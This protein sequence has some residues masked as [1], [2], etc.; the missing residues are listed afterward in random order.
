LDRALLGT[1][2]G[3]LSGRRR[4]QAR[5]IADLLPRVRDIRRIGC[6]AMDLC[7]VASGRLDAYFER[8]LHVWDMAAAML[9][10][11][12]AGGVVRGLAGAAPAEEM[13]V[14]AAPP[15]VDL[16]AAELEALGA[17]SDDEPSGRAG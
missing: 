14:A 7:M 3:Y 13:V 10:V 2:F 17:A 11:E 1:G 6:A 12:E 8:G 5:V 15:L 9:V 16:L 4:S